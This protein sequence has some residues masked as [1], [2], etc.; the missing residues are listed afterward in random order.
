TD[1]NLQGYKIMATLRKKDKDYSS[2]EIDVEAKPCLPT[3][4]GTISFDAPRVR[5]KETLYLD[6][7]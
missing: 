7:A 3:Y 2:F 1:V 4:A 5:N 6:A